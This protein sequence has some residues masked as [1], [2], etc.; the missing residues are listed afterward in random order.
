MLESALIKNCN[1]MI[2]NGIVNMKIYEMTFQDVIEEIY[3][4]Q[5]WWEVTECNI[6]MHLLAFKDPWATIREILTTVKEVV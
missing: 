3:P 2:D 5:P 4:G 6:F 1:A